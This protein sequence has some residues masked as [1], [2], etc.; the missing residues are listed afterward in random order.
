METQRKLSVSDIQ[1]NSLIDAKNV[2]LSLAKQ[3]PE[4]EKL[5]YVQVCLNNKLEFNIVKE[6]KVEELI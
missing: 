3:N 1:E 6:D 4:F 5:Y 2:L